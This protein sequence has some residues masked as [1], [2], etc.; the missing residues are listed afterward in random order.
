MTLGGVFSVLPT[1][2]RRGGEVDHDSLARVVDLVVRAGVQGVTALGVTGEVARLAERERAAIVTTVIRQI[3]GRAKVI[4]GTSA[5][6]VRT[7][8]EF[9]RDAKQ[10][11]ANAVMVS[12]PRM[13][14]LNSESVV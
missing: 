2:F 8:I 4:V 3:A 9:S 6:G 14:K 1:P 13:P 5:D 12:P 7:C 10:L 11:G